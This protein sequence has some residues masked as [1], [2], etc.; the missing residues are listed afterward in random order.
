MEKFSDFARHAEEE[1]WDYLVHLAQSLELEAREQS[2]ENKRIRKELQMIKSVIEAYLNNEDG[3]KKFLTGKFLIRVYRLLEKLEKK[4]DKDDE[5]NLEFLAFLKIL[6]RKMEKE[7]LVAYKVAEK[8]MEFR[9]VLPL[10][11]KI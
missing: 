1:S 9:K 10:G 8:T 6:L 3:R 2:E 4:L 7:R 5:I 11:D